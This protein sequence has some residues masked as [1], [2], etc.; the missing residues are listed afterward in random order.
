MEAVQGTLGDAE[1][2]MKEGDIDMKLQSFDEFLAC[3]VQ[4]QQGG[5]SSEGGSRKGSG[6]LPLSPT[7]TRAPSMEDAK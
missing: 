7:L 1:G 2:S 6:L 3:R 5:S 4:Q